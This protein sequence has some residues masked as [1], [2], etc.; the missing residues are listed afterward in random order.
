MGSRL[1]L[2]L[3]AAMLAVPTAPA[4]AASVKLFHDSF[5]GR[6]RTPFGAVPA[7]SKVTLRLRVTGAKPRSVSLHFEKRFVAMRRSGQLWSA[8]VV[9]P[10]TPSIVHYDF[11][12][13]VGRRT[14]WYGDNGDADTF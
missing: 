9:V 8:T 13:R 12:V 14:L 10:R 6:Y 3:A 2:A 11:R 7:G 4:A 5:D 1:A